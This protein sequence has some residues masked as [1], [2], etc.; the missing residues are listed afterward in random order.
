MTLKVTVGIEGSAQPSLPEVFS[1]QAAIMTRQ[2]QQPINP[3]SIPFMKGLSMT[4]ATVSSTGAEVCDAA[5]MFMNPV[6]FHVWAC[7]MCVCVCVC[8]GGVC[9]VSGGR[10]AGGRERVPLAP[11]KC[12]DI[13]A[14]TC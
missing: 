14:D 11:L 12:A 1:S 4:E 3:T 13:C 9:V 2:K 8:V 5:V 7:C 10:W 6:H